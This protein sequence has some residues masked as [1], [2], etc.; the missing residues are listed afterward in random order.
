MLEHNDS[1]LYPTTE[2]QRLRFVDFTS[3]VCCGPGV[4][5]AN[6]VGGL[7]VRES[8]SFFL[9]SD[10]MNLETDLQNPSLHDL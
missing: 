1:R 7:A 10:F 5:V 3:G 8:E 9:T 4:R 6:R 2:V